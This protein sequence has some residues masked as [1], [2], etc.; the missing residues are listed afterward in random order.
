[1][2]LVSKAGLFYFFDLW[3]CV[4]VGGLALSCI[5]QIRRIVLQLDIKH[6][7]GRDDYAHGYAD[8]FSLAQVHAPLH[9]PLHVPLHIP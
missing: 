5:I 1:M 3:N 6:T 9:A 7:L 8:L 4:T 2:R